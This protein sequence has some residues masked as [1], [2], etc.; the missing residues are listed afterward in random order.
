MNFTKF[1]SY[2]LKGFDVCQGCKYCVY[3]K[4]LVLFVSGKC[5]RNCKYCSLSNKRKNIDK[6][7]ANERECSDINEILEEA[8][9]SKACGAGITGG[10]PLLCLNKTIIFIRALKKK[11]GKSFHVHIYLPTQLVTEEKLKKL[12]DAGIDEIRFHPKFI[13]EDKRIEHELEKISLASKFWNIKD[14]GIEI[15]MFPDKLNET[16]YFL[17]SVSELIGFVNLNELEIS[18]TNFDFIKRKYKLNEDTY[19]IKGSREAGIEILKKCEKEKLGLKVHLC[20][21]RTKNL[22]QYKNRVKLRDILPFGFK[23]KEGS[24]RYFAIYLKKDEELYRF[25]KNISGMEFFF[26]KKKNRIILSEKSAKKAFWLGYNVE[27]VE[28]LP[29]FDGTELERERLIFK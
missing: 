27:R 11:F 24:V 15:P 4:K 26:D 28:E 19:T 12:K 16:F 7:W 23:T 20:T 10:D 1:D 21:A 6:V 2:C 22:F 29:T 13:E 8:V 18:D 25:R 14:I 5:S 17:K 3:G 9:E